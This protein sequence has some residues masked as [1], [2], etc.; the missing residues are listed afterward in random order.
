MW[1][2]GYMTPPC[3][4]GSLRVK[5]IDGNI[6]SVFTSDI[7]DDEMAILTDAEQVELQSFLRHIK[8]MNSNVSF[9]RQSITD[10]RERNSNGPWLPADTD[11]SAVD[12]QARVV[13]AEAHTRLDKLHKI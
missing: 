12:D 8:F 11:L 10:I 3:A 13:A 5:H 1:P 7:G 4:G 2:K 9:V 6:G